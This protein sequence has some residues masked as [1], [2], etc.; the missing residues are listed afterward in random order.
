MKIRKSRDKDQSFAYDI[1]GMSLGKIMAIHSALCE[2]KIHG[3][4]TTIGKE[5]LEVLD[6]FLNDEE[7]RLEKA[8]K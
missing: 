5:M 6:Q 3:T 8:A 7:K 1:I 4:I 2:Q